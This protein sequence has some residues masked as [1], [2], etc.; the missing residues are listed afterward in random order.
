MTSPRLWGQLAVDS[1]HTSRRNPPPTVRGRMD[2]G[3][4]A[5]KVFE[6]RGLGFWQKNNNY[7][8]HNNNNYN[9]KN[10][11]NN[12]YNQHNN[13]SD[14]VNNNK[15]AMEAEKYKELWEESEESKA[16]LERLFQRDIKELYEDRR[17]AANDMAA[18]EKKFVNKLKALEA[19]LN[20]EKILNETLSQEVTMLKMR[21]EEHALSVAENKTAINSELESK[22]SEV[23]KL[24]VQLESNKKNYEKKLVELNFTIQ[25]MKKR[26]VEDSDIA[27]ELEEAKKKMNKDIKVLQ[28]QI[29][30]LQATNDRLD[31]SK[32]NIQSELEDATIELE[33]QRTKGLDLEKKQKN[34]DKVLAEEKAVNDQHAQERDAAEREAREKEIKVLSLTRELDE[35]YE[36]I[37]DLETKRKA[38]QNELES[39]FMEFEQKTLNLE[40]QKHYMK[41]VIISL[42]QEKSD[43]SS[44]FVGFE[45]KILNL[46]MENYRM[47]TV[48]INLEQEKN[49]QS[50]KFMDFERNI[51]DLEKENHR[52]KTVIIKLEQQKSDLTKKLPESIDKSEKLLSEK[53]TLSTKVQELEENSKCFSSYEKVTSFKG[54]IDNFCVIKEETQNK[55]TSP[56]KQLKNAHAEK[57]VSEY[58]NTKTRL[59]LQQLQETTYDN[60]NFFQEPQSQIKQQESA[61]AKEEATIASLAKRKD[62]EPLGNLLNEIDSLRD[63][64][65]SENYECLTELLWD[66]HG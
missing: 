4:V 34:F 9:H 15:A 58:R 3:S 38:L 27:K 32:T 52:M 20:N 42:E 17:D 57:A 1:R 26:S 48:I 53:D 44:K 37:D 36:K 5:A 33:T 43:I 6:Y 31:K 46:E 61:H 40:K 24:K 55:L 59:K 65:F 29:F 63:S 50:S 22:E 35:A 10:Y 7:Y 18:K 21:E 56:L 41:T 28:R 23:R 16:R 62:F 51:V 30:E 64:V 54:P 13:N 19:K 12:G 25:E 8:N 14:A 47:E 45:R 66:D 49:D 60:E 11:N 39:K 2:N